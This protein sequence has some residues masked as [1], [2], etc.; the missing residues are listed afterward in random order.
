MSS[1]PS[2]FRAA[3]LDRDGVLIEDVD[4]LIRPAQIR[5][6]PGVPQALRRLAQAGFR[7]IVATNQPIVARGLATEADLEMLHAAIAAHL[8]AAGAPPLDRFYF[9]PHH[10]RATLPAYRLICDCR[11][12]RP[13]LLLRAA[14]DLGL[15]L[16]ASFMVGDR[17]TD[18]AAGAAAGCRTVL[19]QTGKHLL[20]PIQT[21]EP[22]DPLLKP[23]WTC[24]NLPA[25]AE[26]ILNNP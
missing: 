2:L 11:K 26:W 20:P 9:C 6:L 25:A 18:I 22:M 14:A 15:D 17:P 7:L 23:D 8:T 19:V 3:F 21:A 10:P 1:P 5:V 24:P 13:G 16:R 4:W 12:P